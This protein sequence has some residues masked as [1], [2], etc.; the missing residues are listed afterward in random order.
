MA[1]GPDDAETFR[2]YW[3]SNGMPFPGLPDPHHDVAD[4]YGQQVRLLK[5]GRLPALLV[6]D[7]MGLICYRHYADS[8]Q[9]IPS[10]DEVLAVLDGLD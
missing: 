8:M 7:K 3:A 4:A 10:N 5:F 6:V 9:D 1:V 2:R